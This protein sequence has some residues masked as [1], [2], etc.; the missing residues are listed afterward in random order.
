MTIDDTESV[1]RSYIEAVSDHNLIPLQEL[2]DDELIATFAGGISDKGAWI[3]ALNRLLPALVRNDIRDI[4]V[5]GE[6]A[7]VVYDFVTNTQGG[8]IACVELLTVSHGTIRSIELMLDRVAF[9]PVNKELG[10]R[11][12]QPG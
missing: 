2:L 8:T 1:A 12:A 11:A 9:A 3:S 5:N 4:F 10:E 6:R 7:C